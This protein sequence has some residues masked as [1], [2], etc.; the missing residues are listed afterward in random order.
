MVVTGRCHLVLGPALNNRQNVCFVDCYWT[1]Q[2][3]FVSTVSC[4]C[5]TMVP[6]SIIWSEE[7]FRLLLGAEIIK[8]QDMPDGII[9]RVAETTHRLSNKV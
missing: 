8:I 9:T 6:G 7:L 5:T 3:E 1:L 2:R 4:E